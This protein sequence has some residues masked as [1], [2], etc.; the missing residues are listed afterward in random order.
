MSDSTRLIYGAF[1]VSLAIHLVVLFTFNATDFFNLRN[2]SPQRVEVS[3]RA[4]PAAPNP[5]AVLAAKI[6]PKKEPIYQPKEIER[7][8]ILKGVLGQK[9]PK[10]PDNLKIFE[11]STEKIVKLN[12]VKKVSIDLISSEKVNDPVYTSNKER[13][14][15]LIK[16][17]V[18]ENYANSS[19][20]AGGV[21]YLSFILS[22]E[23]VLLQVKII[24]ERSS[25]NEELRRLAVE[26]LKEVRFSSLAKDFNVPEIPFSIQITFSTDKQ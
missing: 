16:E 11:R 23:G 26:S 18:T 15:A 21:I 19:R 1:F 12:A 10:S 4:K 22:R 13:I 20:E 9:A 6:L 14:A 17:K 8:E 2:N 3:L 24:E 25:S 5:S 7:K